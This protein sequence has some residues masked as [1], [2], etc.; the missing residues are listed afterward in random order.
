MDCLHFRLGRDRYA[1]A[2]ETVGAVAAVPSLRRVPAAPRA[3]LGVA[4]CRGEIVTVLDLPWLLD[5]SAG[6]GEPSIV[7]L[8]GALGA[9]ALYV[10]AALAVSRAD[11][12]RGAEEDA[13]GVFQPMSVTVGGAPH[14]LLSPAGIVAA[15]SGRG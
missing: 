5:E 4:E 6:S 13:R 3:I 14:R 1:L 8:G 11:A 15:A 12:V 2:V 10:P 9:S 7:V